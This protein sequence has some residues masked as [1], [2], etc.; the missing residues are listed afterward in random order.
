MDGAEPIKIA[1]IEVP[2]GQRT[3]LVDSLLRLIAE[4]QAEIDGLRAEIARLKGLPPRPTIRR[5]RRN[6]VTSSKPGTPTFSLH[7]CRP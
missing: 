3:P 5:T 2:P 4:Q 7:W 1:G 6:A